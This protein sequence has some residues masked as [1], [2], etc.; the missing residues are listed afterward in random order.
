LSKIGSLPI[1][2]APTN[3]QKKLSEKI[4]FLIDEDTVVS[5]LIHFFYKE[6]GLSIELRNKDGIKLT[7][8]I[9]LKQVRDILPIPSSSGSIEDDLKVATRIASSGDYYDTDWVVRILEKAA[10]KANSY[11]DKLLIIDELVSLI[12][13]NNQ[14]S[15][16]Q[17]LNVIDSCFKEKEDHK[18]VYNKLLESNNSNAIVLANKLNERLE[19]KN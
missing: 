9:T 11:S 14:L 7:N 2:K 13:K 3:I 5:E 18:K 4:F 8:E 10:Y 15:L 6:G 17:N 19:L 16:K 1:I 12:Q